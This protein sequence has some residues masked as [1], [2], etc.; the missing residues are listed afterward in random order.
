[1]HQQP[2]GRQAGRQAAAAD[3]PAPEAASLSRSTHVSSFRGVPLSSTAAMGSAVLC[4]KMACQ[5]SL[6]AV[7]LGD[8]CNGAGG[9]AGGRRQAFSRRRRWAAARGMPQA[10]SAGGLGGCGPLVA[11][12][13][14]PQPQPHWQQM[15][16]GSSLPPPCPHPD[17]AG[18]AVGAAREVPLDLDAVWAQARDLH[19]CRVRKIDVAP[20]GARGALRYSVGA[21]GGRGGRER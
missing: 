14:A 15:P 2:A 21:K 13:A 1:M 12:G 11:A 9:G 18:D 5:Y 8:S 17:A 20:A 19:E 16:Q 6:T 4:R 10:G 7:S 3:S